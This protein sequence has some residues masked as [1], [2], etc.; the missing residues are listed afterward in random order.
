M[1]IWWRHV[2]TLYSGSHC[3]RLKVLE[4]FNQVQWKINKRSSLNLVYFCRTYQAVDSKRNTL[5]AVIL[6]GSQVSWNYNYQKQITKCT[7]NTN[8]DTR[9]FGFLLNVACEQAH[10]FGRDTIPKQVN[11]LGGCLKC[12]VTLSFFQRRWHGK[13]LWSISG[14]W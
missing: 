11:L 6:S 12:V 8:F 9:L 13:N 10:L 2:N 4:N 5:I 7:H 3:A 14:A 1:R